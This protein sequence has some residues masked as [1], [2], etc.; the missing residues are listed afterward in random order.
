MCET[1]PRSPTM[2]GIAV[3]TIVWSRAAIS[4]P[5][6]SA[7]KIRLTR[8]RVRTMGG[9]ARSAVGACTGISI[10]RTSVPRVRGTGGGADGDGRSG[11]SGRGRESGLEGVPRFVHE[12]GERGGEIGGQPA[13]QR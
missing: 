11:G 10:G 9:A 8:R 12:V 1:P 7:E 2:V 13:V 4:M 5:A 3:E 6:S